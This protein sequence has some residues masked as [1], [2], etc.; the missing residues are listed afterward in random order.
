MILLILVLRQHH[1]QLT[2]SM[3]SLCKIATYYWSRKESCHKLCWYHQRRHYLC[4]VDGVQMHL[5]IRILVG[6]TDFTV[7]LAISSDGDRITCSLVHLYSF[8]TAVKNHIDKAIDLLGS[9]DLG[10]SYQIWRNSDSYL[11]WCVY[12]QQC[13]NQWLE[14]IL[15]WVNHTDCTWFY[16]FMYDNQLPSIVLSLLVVGTSWASGRSINTTR[17]YINYISYIEK[18]GC[19]YDSDNTLWSISQALSLILKLTFILYCFTLKLIFI[20][21]RFTLKVL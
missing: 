12:K 13:D 7:W 1:P 2:I 8:H 20:L 3:A 21:E 16:L 14:G 9:F 10:F 6:S 4:F 15:S 11:I 18:V 5:V 19:M 17:N